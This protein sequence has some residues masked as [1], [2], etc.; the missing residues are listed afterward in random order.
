M[1]VTSLDV[2][3]TAKARQE[4]GLGLKM[5]RGLFGL[6]SSKRRLLGGSL[7]W[8]VTRCFEH[9]KVVLKNLDDQRLS[10]DRI[11]LYQVSLRWP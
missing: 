1:R 9:T 7:T 8:W 3:I 5:G 10:I 6:G 11:D 2:R 4:V